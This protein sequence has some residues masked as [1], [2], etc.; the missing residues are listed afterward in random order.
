[1]AEIMWRSSVTIILLFSFAVAANA[2][3]LDG[4]FGLKL[5]AELKT[6][7]KPV[8]QSH[9]IEGIYQVDVK[10]KLPKFERYLVQVQPSTKKIHHIMAIAEL[11]SAVDCENFAYEMIY[12]LG[13]KYQPLNRRK[14]KP[15]H[16][17]LVQKQSRLD[18]YCESRSLFIEYSLP[19]LS[20]VAE[21]ERFRI[22][23][24]E[25]FKAM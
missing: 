8:L 9:I 18:A 25:I 3:K 19:K 4:A 10:H 5:G 16:Y 14:D 17:F 13:R 22:R 20:E 15:L 12:L 11:P 2:A 6:A 1:M 24:Q 23:H 7:S 21:Q